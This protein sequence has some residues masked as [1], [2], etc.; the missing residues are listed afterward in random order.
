[1]CDSRRQRVAKAAR[2][3]PSEPGTVADR[4]ARHPPHSP[5]L[6]KASR[7]QRASGPGK[8]F[9]RAAN[10]GRGIS[11][12]AR[13]RRA[14]T[15]I[16]PADYP[17][18]APTPSETEIEHIYAW[19]LDDGHEP[20]TEGE[21]N[22]RGPLLWAELVTL[23]CATVAAVVW[24]SITLYA[25]NG[26][27]LKSAPSA[28]IPS[29]PVALPPPSPE[30]AAPAPSA[31][32]TRPATQGIDPSRGGPAVGSACVHADMNEM[33]VSN[34]GA[35]VRCVCGPL[36]GTSGSRTPVSRST[37]QVGQPG[38]G[39]C[40]KMFPVAKCSMAAAKIA[41][42]QDLTEP[43]YPHAWPWRCP[44]LPEPYGASRTCCR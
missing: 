7:P 18:T 9:P 37:R 6:G 1:M 32:P 24:F 25:G 29:S 5:P 20:P 35:V 10:T 26:H 21:G 13:R 36:T 15:G 22:W 2:I 33:T 40:L 28:S 30:M 43:V 27:T 34:T 17:G 12:S 42:A 8:G 4:H 14:A 39:K 23:L 41:G 38:W 16:G 19:S 11:P 31:E 44:G 3:C